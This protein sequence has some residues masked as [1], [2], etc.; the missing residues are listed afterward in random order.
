[1][2]KLPEHEHIVIPVPMQENLPIGL[3]EARR[4][5]INYLEQGPHVYVTGNLKKP[6]EEKILHSLCI[7]QKDLDLLYR[8]AKGGIRLHFCREDNGL[9]NVIAVPIGE[10][11]SLI[12][13]IDPE[14]RVR[15]IVNTLEPCP[16]LCPPMF[17]ET[18]MNCWAVDEQCAWVD[19]NDE[20]EGKIWFRRGPEGEKVFIDR[21]DVPPSACA[22]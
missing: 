7:D 4:R 9:L 15:P 13:D 11:D 2:I 1:M 17:S 19:P 8:S 12:I 14:L 22:D 16:T 6:G 10:D 21:P 20:Q 3:N 5:H 18:S